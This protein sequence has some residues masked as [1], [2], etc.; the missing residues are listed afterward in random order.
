MIIQHNIQAMNGNR[1][2]KKT[3][4]SLRKSTEKL[5][6]GY[7]INRAA[8]DAA[9]LAISEKMRGQIRGLDRASKNV[10]DGISL[11]QTA[12]GAMA[13]IEDMVHRMRTLSVQAANDTNTTSDREA[14]QQEINQLS[15]EIDRIANT[16]EFNTQKIL[17][18]STIQV[19][20]SKTGSLTELREL[21]K[22]VSKTTYRLETEYQEKV[23]I[24][25]YEAHSSLPD[26]VLGKD[27][28]YETTETTLSG[29]LSDSKNFVYYFADYDEN[30][31]VLNR[32]GNVNKKCLTKEQYNH[33][34]QSNFLKSAKYITETDDNGN[35]TK[36]ISWE[37]ISGATGVSS[38]S[39]FGDLYGS[40]LASNIQ[41]K[42]SINWNYRKVTN[43]T[44]MGI[45][46][47]SNL[48][49]DNIMELVG[50]EEKHGFNSTC[51]T[52]SQHYSISFVNGTGDKA[53]GGIFDVDLETLIE[54]A[55]NGVAITGTDL[56][57]RIME[58]VDTS[59]A[60]SSSFTLYDGNENAIQA[61]RMYG[62]Y[63][64]IMINPDN[65]NQ[66]L[67]IDEGYQYCN[68]SR[69]YES[70]ENLKRWNTAQFG[71]TVYEG[72]DAT[73]RYDPVTMP[74]SLDR[75]ADNS[76]PDNATYTMY[77]TDEETDFF[78]IQAG[79]NGGQE[80]T[81][82]LPYISL[83]KMQ[84][85]DLNVLDHSNAA[86]SID[87]CDEA[88]NYINTERSRMG[89]YQNRMEHTVLNNDNSSENLQASES[90]IRDTDIADEMAK[91][92][93]YN[94]LQQAGQSILAQ[95]NQTTQGVLSLLG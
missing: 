69:T 13:E 44:N 47:F 87:R 93:K 66:L 7:R 34:I 9:G 50:G 15:Q 95:A 74:V 29:Y 77:Y 14:I 61:L 5:S 12:E 52:C 8:D 19:N 42:G 46:D 1:M 53:S 25:G 16:T 57:Q 80:L 89:A 39:E 48:N 62:H 67:M 84:I 82:K 37:K 26:W 3:T 21:Y 78:R 68:R 43:N 17:K 49:K 71:F 51:K 45:V 11:V 23:E 73:V 32:S 40:T 64:T 88:I 83:E 30:G 6:S 24:P 79:A 4:N 33:A 91:Y 20:R 22:E 28:T 92:A 27:P 10:E 2:L 31:N 94:I 75:L 60:M 36:K 56:V 54:K 18:G 90:K 76:D 58:A 35:E 86:I 70:L 81:L 59:G 65:T 85:K 55:N 38:V 72:Q 41:S 63:Q